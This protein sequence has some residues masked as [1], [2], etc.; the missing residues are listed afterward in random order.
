M[1]IEIAEVIKNVNMVEL[2]EKTIYTPNIMTEDER[3]LTAEL[4]K[5]FKHVGETGNDRDC[6]V[7]AFIRRTLQ[8]DVYNYPSEIL[9]VMFDRGNVGEFDDYEVSKIAKNKLVAYEAAKGGNVDRSF[10]D[11]ST[12]TPTWRHLQ[13]ESDISYADLRRNGWKSVALLTDYANE[14]LHNSMYKIIFDIIDTAIASGAGNY[15]NETT[16]KPTAASMDAVAL[17]L[18]DHVKNGKP[19]IVALSKYIQAAS[20]LAGFV[21]DEMKNEVYHNGRLGFYDGCTLMGISSANKLAN[22][23][24]LVKDL[25]MFG[26]AGKIGALDMRGDIRVYETNDNNNEKTAIKVTGFEFGYSFNN[27]SLENVC[28]MV[29]AA[30]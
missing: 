19:M 25:R 27:T 30:S 1:A 26:I 21:S 18:N 28:K 22:G 20:K 8:E 11:Y 10:L 9:D 23:D 24:P 17:Y 15:I 14:T 2:A 13:V 29:I 5:C 6:E 7:A 12:L 3:N 16:A 4:D